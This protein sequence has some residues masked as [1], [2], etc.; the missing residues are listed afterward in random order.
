MKPLIWG[1]RE[2]KY[3]F[4]Q[5]WTGFRA[6]RFFA[7][8]AN[9]RG[10]AFNHSAACK[11]SSIAYRCYATAQ[12]AEAPLR[13]KCV[14]RIGAEG[15]IRHLSIGV[16]IRFAIA[17]YGPIANLLYLKKKKAARTRDA[18]GR[19]LG[20]KR[21]RASADTYVICS[22]AETPDNTGGSRPRNSA[23]WTCL[24][25]L[26]L[27][28]QSRWPFSGFRIRKM[29]PLLVVLCLSQN[30]SADGIAKAYSAILASAAQY[31]EPVIGRAFARPVG[32]CALKLGPCRENSLSL[33]LCAAVLTGC[34][35]GLP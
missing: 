3:F 12:Y 4:A 5:V 17:P 26:T 2:A 7:R 29:V 27:P 16:A 8:R 25:D 10:V 11:A 9:H 35:S 18:D 31:A 13:R 24:P 30:S 1:R 33:S 23:N 32:Y 20:R 6:R 14:G 15:V 22:S 28:S 34:P 21:P 19:S